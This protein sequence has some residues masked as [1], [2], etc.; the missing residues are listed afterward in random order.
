MADGNLL[1]ASTAAGPAF[2]GARISCGMRGA[3][4]AIEKIVV[5]GRLRINVIGNVAPSG[6]C[7]SGL[8]DAAAELLRHGLLTSQGRLATPE[9]LPADVPSDLAERIVMHNGQASFLLASQSETGNGS[10]IMLT[11]RDLRELQLATGAIRA[12]ITLLLKQTGLRPGSLERVLIAGGFG[13]FIRRS[14]AQRIGLLPS[15]IEHRR[16]RY[17]GNTSLAGS[18]L[19]ALSRQARSAAEQIAR[20]SRHIDLSIDK[21]FNG[22][23]AE[24]MIFP[25]CE[26]G[27]G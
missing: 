5:D 15:E 23:F 9:Q 2:E 24:A 11:Q 1:A 18:R 17:V 10:P 26:P 13:N 16:I 20:R 3:V 4:G 19:V 7:G 22:A 21:S 27:I 12:G 6:L 8:I 14:N 25:E